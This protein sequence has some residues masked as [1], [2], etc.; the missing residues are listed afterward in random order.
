[1]ETYLALSCCYGVVVGSM[2]VSPVLLVIFYLT[3]TPV[4]LNAQRTIDVNVHQV[5]SWQYGGQSYSEHM[6]KLRSQY[7]E[8]DRKEAAA[9][10]L[11]KINKLKAEQLELQNEKARLEN[12]KLKK[13]IQN[14]DNKAK[15]D[16]S[17]TPPPQNNVSNVSPSG[18]SYYLCID[19]FQVDGLAFGKGHVVETIKENG[20]VYFD[21]GKKYLLPADHITPAPVP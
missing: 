4:L 9:E 19:D 1:M 2:K 20:G 10:A 6:D 12:E 13:E 17:A 3:V 14:L 7:A 16:Q 21:Y 5:E 18:K 15:E 11:Q 8:D